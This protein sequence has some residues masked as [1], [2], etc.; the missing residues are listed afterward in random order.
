MNKVIFISNKQNL[1]LQ[2]AHKKPFPE[3]SIFN[4]KYNIR[5][6]KLLN[7][8]ESEVLFA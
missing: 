1:N 7:I 4:K 6:Q 2:F 3:R 5:V 8:Q